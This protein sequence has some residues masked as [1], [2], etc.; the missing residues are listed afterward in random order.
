MKKKPIVISITV[1]LFCILL[2]FA[3]YGWFLSRQEQV[4]KGLAKPKFPYRNYSVSEMKKMFPQY[5][6]EGV[7]TT[8]TPEQTYTKFREYIKK[9]DTES[10]IKLLYGP[11][12]NEYKRVFNDT[13]AKGELNKIYNDLEEKIIRDEKNCYNTACMYMMKTSKSTV[14]FIKDGKGIWL[15]TNL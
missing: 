15:I 9:G 14:G 10:A 12:K 5:L 2:I 1:F 6:N 4:I 7:K 8:Q 3:A 11:Y 13:K